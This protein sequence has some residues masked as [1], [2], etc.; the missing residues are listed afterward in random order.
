MSV[1][2]PA[3]PQ[4]GAKIPHDWFG[5]L[6]D[7]IRSLECRGD[8]QTTTVKRDR[9]GTV[10]RAYAGDAGGYSG[11]TDAII[12][13]IDTDNSDG[14]YDATE[15]QNSSGTFS[16]ISTGRGLTFDSGN[17]G[18]LYEINGLT[19]V[20][21][22]TFVVVHRVADVSG[23]PIWYFDGEAATSG[24]GVDKGGAW[25]EITG[26]SGS[27]HS[28]KQK[29]LDATTDTTPAVT[30]T[31]D[32]Y[33]V[34][35]RTGIPTGSIVWARF[36]GTNYR[37]TYHGADDGT[38]KNLKR[39]QA[40]G[41][42]AMANSWDRSNQGTD[43]GATVNIITGLWA[44]A[45]ENKLYSLYRTTEIDA[46]GHVVLLDAED[47][48]HV[49]TITDITDGG[50]GD[51]PDAGGQEGHYTFEEGTGTT[52]GDSSGA[53]LDGTASGGMSWSTGKIGSYA[54]DFDG[55]D[56]YVSMSAPVIPTGAKT[57]AVW[58]KT[59]QTSAGVICS[60]E[61]G[62]SANH[63]VRISSSSTEF[64]FTVRKG[65]EG[66]DNFEID[67]S[68]INSGAWR[69]VACTWDGTTGAGGAKVYIDG[70]EDS[71]STATTASESAGSTNLNVGRYSVGSG[72]YDGE[73]DDLRIY[74]REL[75]AAEI[76]D[77]ASE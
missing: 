56:D 77:L 48:E 3:R 59:S 29:D 1:R 46:N 8:L 45:S 21:V 67:A 13:Q 20:P 57:I 74:G 44:D 30:G 63:G 66:S 68:A 76:S 60:T 49:A 71:T 50:S 73:M 75:S 40:T 32:L 52:V 15:Q 24:Y 53:G 17:N 42:P 10:V 4:K 69:H 47:S 28:W 5:D 72:W 54:G 58:L 14:T 70:T 38:T 11:R 27:T 61:A 18:N 34:D 2:P 7:Y 26:A 41:G 35:G 36:D 9:S 65:T 22:G 43:R 6:Y 37:A 62:N 33:E 31:N 25:V 23:D 51:P 39:T 16:D 55:T 64:R 12:A 19:G